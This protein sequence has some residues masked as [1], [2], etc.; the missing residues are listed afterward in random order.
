MFTDRRSTHQMWRGRPGVGAAHVGPDSV[1]VTRC[2]PVGPAGPWWPVLL[3]LL[4]VTACAGGRSDG[5]EVAPPS[6]TSPP[7]N[8]V[9]GSEG[10]EV[11]SLVARAVGP[12]ALFVEPNAAEPLD[13]LE[14][15]TSY[16]SPR[17][18]LVSQTVGDWHR[19]LLPGRPNGS[20]AWV[21]DDDVVLTRVNQRLE[22]DLTEM[23]LTLYEGDREIL[24]SPVAVGSAQNPTPTGLYYITDKIR[25]AAGEVSA[26]GP[27]ALG[28]SA[29]SET[30]TEFAG[31]EGQIAVQGTNDES[32][33]GQRVS[34]GSIR[35][36]NETIIRLAE[37][38]PLGVPVVIVP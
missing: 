37:M 26:Y 18:L 22:V 20:S 30:L 5:A 15:T 17:V 11:P 33:I 1:Q 6:T 2:R 21:R 9:P 7:R 8:V 19:V 23:T 3:L 38:L 34:H 16:G 14:S 32:T 25:P 31:G 27:F 10:V 12:V 28:L 36:P 13:I 24:V 29:H 35:V 4:V